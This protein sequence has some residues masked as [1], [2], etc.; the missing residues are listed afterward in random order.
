[1]PCLKTM[2]VSMKDVLTGQIFY[3]LTYMPHVEK[4]S[5]HWT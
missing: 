5:H 1:M 4:N 2:P 3:A